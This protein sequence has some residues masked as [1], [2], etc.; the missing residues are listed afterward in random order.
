MSQ[1]LLAPQ[2]AEYDARAKLTES[3]PHLGTVLEK[4]AAKEDI[5]ALLSPYLDCREPYS[6]KDYPSTPLEGHEIISWWQWRCSSEPFLRLLKGLLAGRA[7]STMA[8]VQ[9]NSV[10]LS[11][12]L[13]REGLASLQLPLGLFQMSCSISATATAWF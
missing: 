3:L 7:A 4:H 5:V 12:G 13:K 1:G 10:R 9:A 11:Q 2:E 6:L 8:E